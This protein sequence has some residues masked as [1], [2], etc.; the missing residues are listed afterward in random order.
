MLN[1]HRFDVIFINIMNTSF[2]PQSITPHRGDYS[3]FV[4]ELRP[5]AELATRHNLGIFMV[6]YTG[7]AAQ[8][9]YTDLLD[10]LLGSTAITATATAD[11]VLVIQKT[12]DSQGASLYIE[13]KRVKSQEL[14]LE[15]VDGNCYRIVGH[16]KDLARSRKEAQK[17]SV[18]A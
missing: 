8:V 9:H 15:K 14:G 16:A 7:K 11:W 10:H 4:S 12:Q 13:G 6:Q 3:Y 2:T 18:I 1:I 5:W 17:K